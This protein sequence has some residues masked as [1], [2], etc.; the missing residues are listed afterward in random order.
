MLLIFKIICL[1]LKSNQKH[2]KQKEILSHLKNMTLESHPESYSKNKF[3]EKLHQFGTMTIVYDME[4]PQKKDI[5]R[6]SAKT[7]P[8]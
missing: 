2:K 7:Y 8:V 3:D 5:N 4:I 1:W 6:N